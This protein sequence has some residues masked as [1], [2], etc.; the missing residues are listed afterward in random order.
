M[1]IPHSTSLLS[2]S[3]ST[4]MPTVQITL[5]RMRPDNVLNDCGSLKLIFKLFSKLVM[6]LKGVTSLGGGWVGQS[7]IVDDFG[8][9]NGG[10]G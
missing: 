9:D 10:F 3:R 1:F 2:L 4:S 6:L 8:S 7:S 5:L